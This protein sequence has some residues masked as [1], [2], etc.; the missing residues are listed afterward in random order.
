MI[1]GLGFPMSGYVEMKIIPGYEQLVEKL[2]FSFILGD[3]LGY[4]HY[5]F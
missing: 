1:G 2:H 5:L 3:C 4:T